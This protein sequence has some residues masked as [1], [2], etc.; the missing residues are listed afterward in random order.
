VLKALADHA[1]A[2]GSAIGPHAFL[3]PLFPSQATTISATNSPYIF[4]KETLS[5]RPKVH[6]QSCR[7]ISRQLA[8]GMLT[9]TVMNFTRRFRDCKRAIITRHILHQLELEDS[10]TAET[11]QIS[12]RQLKIHVGQVER[13]MFTLPAEIPAMPTHVYNAI[14]AMQNDMNSDMI[15]FVPDL[16]RSDPTSD[17]NNGDA[18]DSPADA[19][20]SDEDS[21]TDSITTHAASD[22]ESDSGEEL[23][24]ED[25]DTSDE[26]PEDDSDSP[27]DRNAL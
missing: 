2:S 19:S 5:D 25:L 27:M 21:D 11:T 6:A 14:L 1:S 3:Q 17:A 16:T 18:N 23:E 15:K 13:N 20:D 22:A 10:E 7:Y 8:T 9:S 4:L 12:Q 24:L 26:E